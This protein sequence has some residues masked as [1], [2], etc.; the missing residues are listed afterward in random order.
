M[1]ANQFPLRTRR[2]LTLL[3][4]GGLVG[5]FHAS[6]AAESVWARPDAA[7]RLTYQT[8][9]T[10]DRLL[11]FSYAGYEGGGVKI[12]ENLSVIGYDNMNFTSL[13]SPRPATVEQYKK[14]LGIAASEIILERINSGSELADRIFTPIL[15]EGESVKD[16]V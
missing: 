7:G 4:A 10:G 1:T 2:W 3:L 11:D 6:S 13:L 15:H 12:P 9:P 5:H 16:M 14:E 8:M